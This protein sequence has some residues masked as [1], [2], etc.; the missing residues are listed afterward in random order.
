MKVSYSEEVA[1]HTDLESCVG[2]PRGRGEALTEESMGW[3]LNREMFD[4]ESADRLGRVWKATSC[5]SFYCARAA[6]TLRGLRSHART[7][8]LCT[9]V[10]RAH[11]RPGA[12]KPQKRT[13]ERNRGMQ[14]T[15]DKNR[16]RGWPTSASRP[17]YA[18]GL[19]CSVGTKTDGHRD[20]MMQ[21]DGTCPRTKRVESAQMEPGPRRESLGRRRR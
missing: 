8:T 14:L 6:R 5:R 3:V 13:R 7:E 4:F 12:A 9:E 18:H 11:S 17:E 16:E 20:V 2:D 21:T 19:A 10:G 15:S 1:N